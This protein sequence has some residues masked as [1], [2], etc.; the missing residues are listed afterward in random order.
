MKSKNKLFSQILLRV[1]C[2][3]AEARGH[4]LSGLAIMFDSDDWQGAQSFSF[5]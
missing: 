2:V 4:V 3:W 5:C 1:V